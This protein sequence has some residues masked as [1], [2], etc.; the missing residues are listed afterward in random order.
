MTCKFCGWESVCDHWDATGD[1]LEHIARACDDNG[2]C[3]VEEDED[4]LV[5]C[6]DYEE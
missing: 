2:H 1:M 6:E 4:S 5:S 3:L